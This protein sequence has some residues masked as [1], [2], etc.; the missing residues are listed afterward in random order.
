[1]GCRRPFTN[2]WSICKPAGVVARKIP[3]RK[4][5]HRRLSRAP[6]LRTT[7]S[8]EAAPSSTGG[9][10]AFNLNT[11]SQGISMAD[12]YLTVPT[13]TI[14][15]LE[16]EKD[17]VASHGVYNFTPT[18]HGGLD[19]RGWVVITVKDGKFVMAK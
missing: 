2:N 3:S 17:I 7:F 8:P 10:G 11:V 18:D 15:A 5:S 14:K 1:M 16:S 4:G 12:F 6:P 19:D 9:A 13:A